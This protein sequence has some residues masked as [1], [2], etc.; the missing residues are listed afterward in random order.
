MEFGMKQRM[1]AV[2]SVLL[3][4]VVFACSDPMTTRE[5]TAGVGAVVG[6]NVGAGIGSTFGYACTGGL[7]ELCLAWASE[8]SSAGQS[9]RKKR[10]ATISIKESN[11]A[12]S[13]YNARV[14]SWTSSRRK[15]K[16]SDFFGDGTS[17]SWPRDG[18]VWQA[19]LSAKPFSRGFLQRTHPTSLF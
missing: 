1:L 17:N 8:P 2:S 10:S 9:R 15:F 14:R 18:N 6:S 5:K 4:T 13:T 19:K 12:T 3:L 11:S 16:D 7:P